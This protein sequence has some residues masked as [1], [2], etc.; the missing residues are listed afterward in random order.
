M[1]TVKLPQYTIGKNPLV[2]LGN[3]AEKYGKRVLIIGGRQALEITKATIEES[4][5]EKGLTIVDCLWYGGECSYKNI[6]IICQKI[7]ANDVELVI[8]VGGGKALDTAKAAAAKMGIPIITVPTIASTCAAT[9]SLSVVYT[10]QGD[11]E[12]ICLYEETPPVHIFISIDILAKAPTKYLW[13][14][15]GDTI[16]KYYEVDIASRGARLSHSEAMG[17]KLSSLC[18]EPLIQYGT[19]ALEDNKQA[20]VSFELQEVVLNIIVTTGIVSMLVGE[21]YVSA[22]AHGLF[23]GLTI[24][25]EIEKHHLHGEV[26]A[27][28]VLVLLML[29]NQQEEVERLISFYKKVELPTSLKDMNIENSKEILDE[30]LEKAINTEDHAKMPYEVSKEMFYEAIQKLEVLNK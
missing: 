4:L 27:Y 24:L 17:K 26:V 20:I 13:A 15:I 7:E 5:K 3:I 28:G 30:V 22:C 19:K 29:D 21:A 14:G 25:E 11:Y 1:L 9:T 12:A 2:E 8:G 16:S 6:D 18:A 23:Y 10:E